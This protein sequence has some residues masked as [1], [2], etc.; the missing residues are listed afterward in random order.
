MLSYW[1]S[2]VLLVW[3]L[4]SCLDHAVAVLMVVKS[5]STIIVKAASTSWTVMHRRDA[6]FSA[7]RAKIATGKEYR[8]S[9]FCQTPV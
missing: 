1:V 6:C 9:G 8:R 5:V 3:V 4:S 2:S 7:G